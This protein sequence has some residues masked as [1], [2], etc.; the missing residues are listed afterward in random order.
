VTYDADTPQRLTFRDQLLNICPKWLKSTY[1]GAV[2][3]AIGI[4]LDAF[5]DE[6]IEGIQKRWPVDSSEDAAQQFELDRQIDRGIDEPWE[7]YQVRLRRWRID[8]RGRG[9][10]YALL[11]QLHAYWAGAFNIS[12]HYYGTNTSF[13]AMA[14]NGAITRSTATDTSRTCGYWS[15]TYDWPTPLPAPYTWGT[16]KWGDGRVWGSGLTPAQVA[17]LRKVPRKWGNAHSRGY[18]VLLYNNIDSL[19]I[20]I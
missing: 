4:H 14:T 19:T 11:N 3:Y 18:L 7:T 8:H 9:G 10:P 16:G 12:L 17:S 20:A 2:M 13:F 5:A 6:L 15:L 1:I